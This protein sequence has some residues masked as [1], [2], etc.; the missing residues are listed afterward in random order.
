MFN[1]IHF[2]YVITI[3]PMFKKLVF[4]GFSIDEH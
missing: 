2:K 3:G 1:Y 4:P